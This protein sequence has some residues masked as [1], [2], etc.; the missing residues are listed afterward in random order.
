[1]FHC[2]RKRQ[3]EQKDLADLIEQNEG[4]RCDL[5][6]RVFGALWE[7]PL[8]LSDPERELDGWTF[9]LPVCLSSYLSFLT[10]RA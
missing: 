2:S 7:S 5:E 4:F 3:Q 9:P 6:R 1:M 8:L 10:E